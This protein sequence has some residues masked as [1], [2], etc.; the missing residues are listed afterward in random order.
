MVRRGVVDG[1]P[2]YWADSPG[3]TFASLIFRV[4]WA[5]ETLPAFGITHLVEHLALH[6]LLY[7]SQVNG[8]VEAETTSFIV[9]GSPEDVSTAVTRVVA[10]LRALPMERLEAERRVLLTEE[11]SQGWSLPSLLLFK[12]YGARGLGM[13]WFSQFGLR[14]ID[15]DEIQAWADARFNRSN[16]ALVVVGPQAGTWS[17]PLPDGRRWAPPQSVA[18]DRELP[19]WLPVSRGLGSSFLVDRSAVG[20]LAIG[21][22]EKR[23]FERL[24][25]QEGIAYQV[26]ADS[27]AVGGTTTHVTLVS[28]VLP[29]NAQQ[30]TDALIEGFDD[31]AAK[32]V[33][34]EELRFLVARNQP[35]LQPDAF[36]GQWAERMATRELCGLDPGS[37]D[38]VRAE[39]E[40][41]TPWAV[42]EQLRIGLDKALFALPPGVGISPKTLVPYEDARGPA[43]TGP[44]LQP[45]RFGPSNGQHIVVA[46]EGVSLVEPAVPPATVRFA[47]CAVVLSF[48]EGARTLIGNDGQ[49]VGVDPREWRD[50]HPAV[51]AIDAA[52]PAGLQV[53]MG[54]SGSLAEPGRNLGVLG[55]IAFFVALLLGSIVVG[56]LAGNLAR[57][58][59]APV[60]PA[61]GAAL[62]TFLLF[63]STQRR[64]LARSHSRNAG[65][66]V[67][68]PT[69]RGQ[70][71]SGSWAAVS[72]AAPAAAGGTLAPLRSATTAVW[73]LRIYGLCAAAVALL[74]A[75]TLAVALTGHAGL[76]AVPL[77]LALLV[78]LIS[79][80][81]VYVTGWI[82]VRDAFR[83][84]LALGVTDL[85]HTPGSAV[86]TLILSPDVAAG[87]AIW[88]ELWSASDPAVVPNLAWNRL[89]RPR[90]PLLHWWYSLNVLSTGANVVFYVWVWF[91]PQGPNGDLLRGAI[92]LA[93]MAMNLAWAAGFLKIV[94]QVTV[95]Q[96]RVGEAS[97]PISSGTAAA[98]AAAS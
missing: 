25:G 9:G 32:A 27:T 20:S 45:S 72:P 43:L 73:A 47:E 49:I 46:S 94:R 93:L 14:H 74:A 2:V 11:A 35:I 10:S 16:A 50:A 53:P 13:N 79:F 42:A 37:A 30:A 90:A 1:V 52:T 75:A 69:Q 17:L 91:L 66:A 21:V 38:Q 6:G 44:S 97:A 83:R 95:N 64:R 87:E 48:D 33:T 71:I 18:V 56:A 59:H 12:R 65:I 40:A 77:G 68:E 31:L 8:R 80:A 98:V 89:H 60:A 96:A 24:R 22:A 78:L 81:G 23:L 7:G 86:R 67:K 92:V 62:F 39:F 26:H 61:I 76:L 5:D 85:A 4:G 34:G 15:A 58:V 57:L 29:A 55:A 63:L 88:H 19:A 51:A 3:L 36:A 70:A 41:A 28:D 82:W 84:L 54:P